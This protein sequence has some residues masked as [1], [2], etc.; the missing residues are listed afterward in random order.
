MLDYPALRAV[1]AVVQSGSFDRAAR[2]LN[3]TPSA[4][5][6]R[7]KQLEERLG[8]ALIVRGQPCTATEQGDRLC[9]HMERVGMLEHGL[10]S[11]MPGLADAALQPVTLQIAVN[12]DS[13]GTWFLAGV[14][15]YARTS[16]HLVSVV[17]ED[18]D[19]TAEWLEKGRVVAAVTSLDK[20]VTGCRRM[21]LGRLR[22][23]ATASPDFM[24]RHFS[25]GVS[26]HTLRRAPAMM[27]NQKDR[28]QDQWIEA[29]FGKSV[30]HP[31]HW[32]PSTQSFVDGALAGIGWGMNPV[33]LAREHLASGR[34]VELVADSPVDVPLYWQVNRLSADSLAALTGAVVTAAR[35]KLLPLEN[36]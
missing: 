31:S 8:A 1:A 22:Y 32:L 27:F 19:H 34:L 25:D 26:L 16:D 18:Q 5:S 20:P 28:L 3:V 17:I 13:L 7:V 36:G 11:Q 23:Q 24:R 10:F 9:R 2:L 33:M 14:A 12:A 30:A 4:V 6:Q 21:A 15:D 35:G 29:V